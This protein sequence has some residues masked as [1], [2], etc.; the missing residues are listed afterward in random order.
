MNE[1]EQL[2]T[3]NTELKKQIFEVVAIAKKL[4]NENEAL[5]KKLLNE[6][7][8]L[9][10]TIDE[11]ETAYRK[12]VRALIDEYEKIIDLM[13][14][15]DVYET[16]K[17]EKVRVPKTLKL[18]QTNIISRLVRKGTLKYIVGGGRG[19]RKGLIRLSEVKAAMALN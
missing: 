14:I 3:E 18:F 4:L 11:R 5:A 10:K 13:S 1:I 6:Q 15:R 17:H 8:A 12:G 19:G 9:Q 7:D 16:L 2:R